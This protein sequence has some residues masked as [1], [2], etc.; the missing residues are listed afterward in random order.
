[1]KCLLVIF[2]LG[3]Y[4]HDFLLGEYE[5]ERIPFVT[6]EECM[7]AAEAVASANPGFEWIDDPSGSQGLAVIRSTVECVGAEEKPPSDLLIPTPE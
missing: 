6:E 2:M 1:M 4:E 5:Y 7:A 3:E